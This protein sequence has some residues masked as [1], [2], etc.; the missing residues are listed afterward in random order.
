MC[1]T[2]STELTFCSMAKYRFLFVLEY[3]SSLTS[4]CSFRIC[5]WDW[6][7]GCADVDDETPFSWILWFGLWK[8]STKCTLFIGYMQVG[9][10]I[11]KLLS[12]IGF[13]WYISFDYFPD[14]IVPFSKRKRKFHT[15]FKLIF[16][17]K[18]DSWTAGFQL[19]RLEIWAN[20][21]IGKWMC[22]MF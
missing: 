1:Q 6:E 20:V 13:K 3:C 14:F 5:F 9:R 4:A 12:F 2:F 11:T 16:T 17:R 15:F 21:R 18:S 8:F 7:T 22:L 19:D 10:S